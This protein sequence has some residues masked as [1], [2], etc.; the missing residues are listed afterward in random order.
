MP[1]L[2]QLK[3]V[4]K[5][6]LADKLPANARMQYDEALRRGLIGEQ[7]ANRDNPNVS[8]P[9]ASVPQQQREPVNT[10]DETVATMV[11]GALA[12]PVAGLAGIVQSIN[13][14]AEEGAGARAVEA[15]KEALTF[16]PRRQETKEFLSNVSETIAPVTEAFSK[17]ERGLGES[18]LEKTGSPALA[19]AAHSIPTAV[20]ELLGVAG[21]KGGIKA[22]KGAEKA[23][24]AKGV[25]K[26]IS[27]AAPTIDE[28]KTTSKVIFDEI[29]ELG[30]TLKAAPVNSFVDEVIKD[31]RKLGLKPQVTPKA[32]GALDELKSVLEK[33]QI[34]LDDLQTARAVA[35]NAASD[36]TNKAE[37]MLG[38]KIIDDIDNFLDKSGVSIIDKAAGNAEDI[39]KRYRTARDLWGRARRSELVTEAFEKAKDQASGFENGLRVQLRQILNNKR[40]KRYFSQPEIEAMKKVVQ[41]TKDANIAKLVGRLGFS[42]SQATNI[43]GGALGAGAGAAMFGTAGAVAVPLIGNVS[44]KLAQRLTLRNAK[45][46]D[47]VIRAGKDA[48][49]ITRAYMKN[50]PKKLRSP[51][52]LSQLLMR[53]DIP[54]D[55]LSKPDDFVKQAA[56]KALENRAILAGALAAGTN[57]QED[58]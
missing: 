35:Q 29:D 24:E 27:K 5:R 17:A 41:G 38:T 37:A 3:E 36:V 10:L 12:E 57:T 53:R 26:E 31:T 1:T 22:A 49:K 43:V 47:D 19:A 6:G 2:E 58:K 11:T 16:K 51:E 15:T 54:L 48:Q 50:T 4:H 25:A 46:A 20:L 30:T 33:P 56:S 9:S 45:F 42:E 52:E 7:D 28:L 32:A 40:Q 23:I 55:S 44:R 39:G 14:F 8:S 34:T 13:P 21:A 18:V